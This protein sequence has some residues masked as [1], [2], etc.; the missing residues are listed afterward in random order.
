MMVRP[1]ESYDQRVIASSLVITPEPVEL[2][3]QYDVFG[4]HVHRARFDGEAD[5]LT[6]ESRVELDHHPHAPS[7]EPLAADKPATY[8]VLYGP[9]DLPDLARSIERAHPDCAAEVDRWARR[10][11]S[12]GVQ[13]GAIALLSAMTRAI[14]QEFGYAARL[15]VGTQTPSDTLRLGTGSCRD[16]AVLMIDAARGLGFA[17]RFVSGYIYSAA[18]GRAT[19]RVG[20]GHTHAWVRVFLPDHG[21]EE[22][23]PTNGI[24]GS[25]DLI[26]VAI[27]RDPRQALPLSGTWYG[28]AASYLGMDVEVDVRVH[29]A[30]QTERKAA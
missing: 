14:H 3:Q 12:P 16:F 7:D 10:F 8:P 25:T 13:V 20:G 30:V 15:E 29:P 11:V 4:N 1:R 26:R 6:I 2:L 24:I 27:A 28:P 19:P 22:F 17:A 9:A 18:G 23:D 5:A 21:W